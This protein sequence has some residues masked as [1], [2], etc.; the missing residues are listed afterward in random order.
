MV[1]IG[2]PSGR[3]PWKVTMFIIPQSACACPGAASASVRKTRGTT[4]WPVTCRP[5]V[6][7][8]GCAFRIESS[9]ALTRIGATAPSLF[10]MSGTVRHFTA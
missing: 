8:G 6:G 4:M 9:G 5:P 3:I 10:G 2:R 1:D 7:K